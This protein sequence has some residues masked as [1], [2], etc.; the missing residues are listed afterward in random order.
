MRSICTSYKY[1]FTDNIQEQKMNHGRER[2]REV[3]RSHKYKPNI[4]PSMILH[5]RLPP[6]KPSYLRHKLIANGNE[7]FLKR[8]YK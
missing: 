8:R 7:C 6:N 5:C 4:A 2:E 3:K 1:L